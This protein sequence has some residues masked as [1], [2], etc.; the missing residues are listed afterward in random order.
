MVTRGLA[1]L[2]LSSKKPICIIHQLHYTYI[3]LLLVSHKAD[4]VI[5]CGYTKLLLRKG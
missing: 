5:L 1:D 4:L 3:I 2:F